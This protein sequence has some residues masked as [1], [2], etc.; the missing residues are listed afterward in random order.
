MGGVELLLDPQRRLVYDKTGRMDWQAPQDGDVMNYILDVVGNEV[1]KLSN[2]EAFDWIKLVRVKATEADVKLKQEKAVMEL[3]AQKLRKMAYRV[4]RTTPG[5]NVLRKMFED[6][7]GKLEG[8][9]A[10]RELQRRKP[11]KILDYLSNYEF[12]VDPPKSAMF[13]ADTAYLGASLGGR[14]IYPA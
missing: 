10:E 8:L 14:P 2:V 5:E 4:K 6:T 13:S 3:R 9:A 12:A 7:A 11:Q 1:D